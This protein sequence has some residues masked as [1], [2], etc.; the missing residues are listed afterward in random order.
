MTHLTDVQ[1]QKLR[2]HLKG[3][4]LEAVITLALATGMRRDELLSLK[5]QNV[6]LDT[7]LLLFQDAKT[8]ETVS[9]PIPADEVLMLL[10][11]REVQMRAQAQAGLTWANRDLVFSGERGMALNSH[12]L[13][14]ELGV[15]LEQ[16]GLPRTSFHDLRRYVKRWSTRN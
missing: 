3:H 10:Q 11:H 12:Q 5:W 1:V 8:R 2:D 14:K 16:A 15:I 9:L 13:V 6:D 7:H 4:H